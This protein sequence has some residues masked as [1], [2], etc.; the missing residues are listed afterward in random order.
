MNGE[1]DGLVVL[2][3]RLA[4]EI[5]RAL[6]V[7]AVLVDIDDDEAHITSGPR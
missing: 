3:G 2:P 1:S 4:A 7:G 6:P 5:V